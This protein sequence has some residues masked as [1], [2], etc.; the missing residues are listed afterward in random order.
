MVDHLAAVL[1]Y[2]VDVS[3]STFTKGRSIIENFLSTH[4]MTV[5]CRKFGLKEIVCK[6]NFEKAFDCLSWN[7]LFEIFL[8]HGFPHICVSWI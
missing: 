2:L 6:Y 5:Q 8:A 4:K 3:Q 1:P 7:F